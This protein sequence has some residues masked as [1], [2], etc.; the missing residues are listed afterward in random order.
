[1]MDFAPV[2]KINPYPALSGAPNSSNFT[3]PQPLRFPLPGSNL[4]LRFTFAEED[5]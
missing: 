5:L 4:A 2:G 1:M 3:K